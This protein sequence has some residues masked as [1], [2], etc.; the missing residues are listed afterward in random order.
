MGLM[1]LAGPALAA[2]AG[3][4]LGACVADAP[5]SETS[6]APA[7]A[8][9]PPPVTGWQWTDAAAGPTV[10]V[11]TTDVTPGAAPGMRTASLGIACNDATPSI[12]LAWDA[13]VAAGGRSALAYSFDGQPTHDVTARAAD[14]QSLVISDPLV[15]SRFIDEAAYSRQLVVSAGA[16]QAAFSTA[17]DAGNLRRF[18]TACPDGTN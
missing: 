13:P 9:I 11:T 1:R 7:V 17:D 18:R 15:V 2:C 14:P 6:I 5:A 12:L 8:P 4:M 10:T 3:L 16:T